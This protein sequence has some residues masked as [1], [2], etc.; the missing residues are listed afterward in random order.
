LGEAPPP[1]PRKAQNELADA[2]WEPFGNQST[3]QLKLS[4]ERPS[5]SHVA[6]RVQNTTAVPGLGGPVAAK[7]P[8]GGRLLVF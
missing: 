8:S 7:F 3:E 6:T 1:E 2:L 4:L 5:E